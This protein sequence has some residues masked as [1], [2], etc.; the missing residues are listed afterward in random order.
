MNT[1]AIVIFLAVNC[2]ISVAVGYK[3][4]T[5]EDKPESNQL[6]P[7]PAVVQ[8]AFP[9]PQSSN[10]SL[11]TEEQKKNEQNLNITQKQEQSL[12]IVTSQLPVPFQ[13]AQVPL[14][15]VA[16]QAS[17]QHE[18]NL[19]NINEKV[20]V[21]EVPESFTATAAP[22]STEELQNICTV[23]GPLDFNSKNSLELILKNSPQHTQL[24]YKSEEKPVFEVYWNLGKDREQAEELLQKQK[25]NGTMS[26]NRFMII[27]NEVQDWIVPIIE[28]N[29]N[30]EVAKET[31]NTLAVAAN[32]NN[33]G[34][35]WQYRTK[36]TAY[37]YTIENF[38]I[39][40]KKSLK[41]ID[42]MLDAPKEPCVK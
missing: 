33:A 26:D 32:K 40:D 35:K 19:K 31:A 20:K 15:I 23:L 10:V 11:N 41:S 29:S 14:V 9:L 24:K 12:E 38:E 6:K 5:N 16:A 39:L 2:V 21:V 7:V 37:F 28:I 18:K 4:F 36:P 13:G 30:I 8:Q 25:L 34:G 27:Q 22:V 17:A 42:V 1:R 3:F